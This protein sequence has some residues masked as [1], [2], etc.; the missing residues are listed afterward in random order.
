MP[1]RRFCLLFGLLFLVVGTLTFF[2]FDPKD[3][4]RTTTGTI[5]D[6]AY[7]SDPGDDSVTTVVYVDYTADGSRYEHAEYPGYNFT[8]DIGDEVK[9]YYMSSDPSQIAGPGKNLMPYVS[10]AAAI[11]GAVFFVVGVRGGRKTN[12]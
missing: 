10:A 5:V 4:D 6:F 7:R 2:T 9:L 3:Y 1:S 8:M 12:T 11:M